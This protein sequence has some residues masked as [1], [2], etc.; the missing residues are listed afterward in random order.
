M[1]RLAQ[2]ITGIVI[3]IT[4]EILKVYYIMPF[5][6]SQ[7]SDS[8][9]I[10]Y[11]IHSNIFYFRTI[12]WLI[13]VFPVFSYY[14]SGSKR[15]K[16]LV[17][18]AL[19]VY[20]YI[21]IL[22]N[23]RFLADKMFIQPQNIVFAKSE[24]NSI[25]TK[26]LIVGVSINGKEKAY[27]IEIIGYHHQVRDT[28]GG[29]PVMV[30]YCTVCRTGRVF[31]PVVNGKPEE[32]RLVGMDHFNAMFEDAETGS[33]WR[34][35]NGEAIAGPLKGSS[36]REIPSQQM[37]LRAW[38]SQYPESQIL[39]PD[40]LF[41]EQYKDLD[42]F[43]EGTIGGSLEHRDSLSWKEKSWVVGV[44]IGMQSRAYDW[45]ELIARKVINDTLAATP[46]LI[47]IENDSISYHVWRRDSLVF[48]L[49]DQYILTD[50]QTH[51][52]WNWKGKSIEGQM[53]GKSLPVVQ[54][55]QEFWHS[56]KTFRPRTTQYKPD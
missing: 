15:S 9:G 8:I 1:I 41:N 42:E 49:S 6:G 11:F 53:S 36:L 46:I 33:W 50:N 29:E 30:T 34:Q 43:D 26:K 10:A 39:Q 55:Y 5:P 31:S 35:V 37:T 28:V 47:A 17:S 24:N 14:L 21:F 27:P 23:F 7:Q 52:V 44:Q 13:I 20:V 51:S 32:F 19:L 54:S 45:N 40:T 16:W 22:F 25:D 3:L 2:F 56:W 38:L 12:G 18:G 48:S 4:I